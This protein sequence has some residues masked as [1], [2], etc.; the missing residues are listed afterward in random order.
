MMRRQQAAASV[1]TGKNQGGLQ[2]VQ[3]SAALG[4]QRNKLLFA[5]E[6]DGAVL[7]L[8][9]TLAK[10]KGPDLF[11]EMLFE[12]FQTGNIDVLRKVTSSLAEQN[13]KIP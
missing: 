7:D 10:M 2:T 11:A 4:S 6:Q 3:K 12:V 1:I 5:L 9:S 8:E 13:D